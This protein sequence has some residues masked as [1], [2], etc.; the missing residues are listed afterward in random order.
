[1]KFIGREAIG[2]FGSGKNVIKLLKCQQTLEA[3]GIDQPDR[4]ITPRSLVPS[5]SKSNQ[6]S[7]S[8]QSNLSN[9]RRSSIE[10]IS[11]CNKLYR[12]KKDFKRALSIGPKK[13]PNAKK[14]NSTTMGFPE[15]QSSTKNDKSQTLTDTNKTKIG[16]GQTLDSAVDRKKFKKIE[17]TSKLTLGHKTSPK[18]PAVKWDDIR[19]SMT[20]GNES[21]PSDLILEQRSVDEDSNHNDNNNNND[22]DD[23]DNIIQDDLVPQSGGIIVE[24]DLQR[25]SSQIRVTT[26]D[27]EAYLVGKYPLESPGGAKRGET[28]QTGN[29]IEPIQEE[30]G[31]DGVEQ[32]LNLEEGE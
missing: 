24:D 16:K 1:M 26:S 23:I 22:E 13:S 29:W 10:S 27:N 19:E 7:N 21:D 6:P 5:N 12:E 3:P 8:K 25:Q 4:P 14:Y 32:Q 15:D 17:L 28:F 31:I 30:E 9:A 20:S 18:L 11:N 2:G